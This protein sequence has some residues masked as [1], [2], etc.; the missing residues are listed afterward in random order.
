MSTSI[1][2]KKKADYPPNYNEIVKYFDVRGRKTIVFTYGDTIYCPSGNLDLS[3]DL[4]AHEAVHIVQ[5]KRV[6]GPKKWWD[7]Y[8]TDMEFRLSQELEAYQEQYKHAK[9]VS[10][11]YARF[12]LRSVSKDLASGM[13]GKMLTKEE[14]KAAISAPAN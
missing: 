9:K 10:R 3:P 7:R 14:A 6:G 2:I 4:E 8:Y 13:Y 12:L 1:K 11:P 5:Q